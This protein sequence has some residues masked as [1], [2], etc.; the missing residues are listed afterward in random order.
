MKKYLLL[1]VIMTALVLPGFAQPQESQSPKTEVV[2]APP[3]PKFMDELLSSYQSGEY[4]TFLKRVHEKYQEASDKW[5]YNHLLEERKKLSSVVQDFDADKS[6]EFKKKITALHEE[7]NREL[8]ELCLSEPNCPLSREVKDMVFFS[9][10]KHEQESLDYLATLN[11]KFKGDG[12]SQLEN[13]LIAIDTEFWLKTL[14]LD[15][16][17]TQNQLDEVTYLKKRAVLQLEKLK[18]MELAVQGKDVDPKVKDYISTAKKIYPKV[19]ASSMTRKFLHDLAT[20]RVQPETAVQEKMKEVVVK[21]HEKQQK[22]VAEYFPE[23][24]K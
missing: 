23:D 20:N 15:V 18:Q 14:A 21:Y 4:D 22:L 5:E 9:P 7:E 13:N 16:L 2:Q 24:Q 17:A 6:G 19:Q 10:S 11:W 3:E 8:V 1:P 12:T